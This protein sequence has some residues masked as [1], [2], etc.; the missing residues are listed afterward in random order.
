MES[1]RLARV[2]SGAIAAVLVLGGVRWAVEAWRRFA[3]SDAARPTWFRAPQMLL[4]VA[5]MTMSVLLIVYLVHFTGSGLVWR[6]WRGVA[7]TFGA[8]AASWTVLWWIDRL[9]LDWIF[10]G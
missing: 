5:G 4:A 9:V 7:I 8:L 10:I 1:D 2:I 6:R 3:V